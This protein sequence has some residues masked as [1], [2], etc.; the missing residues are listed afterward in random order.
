MSRQALGRSKEYPEFPSWQHQESNL[1]PVARSPAPVLETKQ[2][3]WFG[4]LNRYKE[5]IWQRRESQ[6]ARD[7]PTRAKPRFEHRRTI[8]FEIA[9]QH[10]TENVVRKVDW[11]RSSRWER[12]TSRARPEFAVRKKRHP[13]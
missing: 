2:D 12:S 1:L 7:H 11:N 4:G 3:G 8:H 13:K 5:A 6:P 9:R 10:P